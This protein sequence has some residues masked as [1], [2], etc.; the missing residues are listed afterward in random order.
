LRNG[1]REGSDFGYFT[2]LASGITVLS[3][4][5]SNVIRNTEC[6][7]THHSGSVSAAFTGHFDRA[8]LTAAER[9]KFSPT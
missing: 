7:I 5:G 8:D 2:A 6:L 3:T 4:Q 9:W 1:E